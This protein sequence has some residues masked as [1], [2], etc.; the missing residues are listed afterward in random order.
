MLR[1]FFVLSTFLVSFVL[2]AS[3]MS[4]S[5]VLSHIPDDKPTALTFLVLQEAYRRIGIEAK[6]EFLPHERSLRASNSGEVDGEVMRIA[7]LEKEYPN[8]I[9]VPESIYNFDTVAFTTGLVFKIDGWES[10]R[11]YQLC[12]LRGLKLSERGTEGMNR[13]VGN[14]TDHVIEMLRRDRCQVA[15]L[16]RASWLE[17]DRL[18]AGPLRELRP[19]I[20]TLKL[21]HYVHKRHEALVPK[22][23]ET[24]R[25]MRSEGAIAAITA[26]EDQSIVEAKR[27]NSF[28]E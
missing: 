7:G 26:S 24:L 21:F 14:S 20:A 3:A 2:P 16:G 9:M 17:V 28:P 27:R 4:Q 19:P 12:I 25:Q 22:L 1:Q 11:P 23:A 18:K 15:I 6:E 8:L 13:M 10:L 5:V